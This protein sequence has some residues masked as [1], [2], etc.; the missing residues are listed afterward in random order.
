MFT[1]VN[2]SKDCSKALVA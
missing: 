2:G 1:L